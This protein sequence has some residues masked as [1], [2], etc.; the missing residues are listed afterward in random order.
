[1][2]Q[3]FLELAG[4]FLGSFLLFVPLCMGLGY[5]AQRAED[6]ERAR[7]A[8]FT[9]ECEYY[10]ANNTCRL[11]GRVIDPA[12]HVPLTADAACGVCRRKGPRF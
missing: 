1:M 6:R 7:R 11:C 5:V 3:F 2:L 4:Y 10:R 12:K 9:A 8:E